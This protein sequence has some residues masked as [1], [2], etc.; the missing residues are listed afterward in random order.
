[1]LLVKD[2]ELIKKIAIK[3]FDS[4]PEHANFISTDADPLWSKNMFIMPG[5]TSQ[6]YPVVYLLFKC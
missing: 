5:L 6:S 1:M 2:L 4:F 3:D